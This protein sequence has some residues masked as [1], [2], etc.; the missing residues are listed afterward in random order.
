MSLRNIA[1]A[2]TAVIVATTG[3]GLALAQK[4]TGPWAA[5]PDAR[6]D[7][8]AG[9]DIVRTE[10]ARNADGRLRGEVTMAA[11]WDTS[12]LR[13]PAGSQGIASICMRLYDQRDPSAEPPDWLVCATPAKSG[14]ALVGTVLR[15]RVDGPPKR[16]GSARV[17]RPTARTVYLRFSQ[18]VVRRPA[19]L[20]FSAEASTPRE[21]CPKTTGCRDT[22]PNAPASIRLRLRSATGSR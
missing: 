13:G 22:A 1:A 9:L 15:D 4:H 18:T 8:P 5:S 19:V 20:R 17:T 3:T 6:D 16:V 12:H 11:A 21:S 10:L 7:V 14:D 2:A